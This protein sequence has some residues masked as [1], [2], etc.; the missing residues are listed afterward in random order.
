MALPASFGPQEVSRLKDLINDGV[1]TLIEIS[2]L[3]EGMN[4]TISS[5]GEELQ[6]PP[7]LLKKAIA[8]VHKGKFSDCEEEL[9]DLERVLSAS[10]NKQ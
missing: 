4:D 2:S 3:R 8:I 5:I 7:K 10:G 6:I 9:A 1:K